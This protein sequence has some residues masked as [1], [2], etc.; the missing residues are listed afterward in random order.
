MRLNGP[1]THSRSFSPALSLSR[2]VRSSPHCHSVLTSLASSLRGQMQHDRGQ[3]HRG[4]GVGKVCSMPAC[5]HGVFK[6]CSPHNSNRK[7]KLI[8][9]YEFVIKVKW[10]GESEWETLIHTYQPSYI[11]KGRTP[12]DNVVNGTITIP[13]LS[14]E[15]DI[16]EVDVIAA[17]TS[18]TTPERDALYRSL[19]KQATTTV[20]K[21]LTEWLKV[22]R[23]ACWAMPS[24]QQQHTHSLLQLL[25]EQYALDIILPTNH[26]VAQ[27]D[28]APVLIHSSSSSG[29]IASQG[30]TPTP[31]S[32]GTSTATIELR[33]E[34]KCT[35][36]D[37]FNAL[38]QDNVWALALASWMLAYS[39]RRLS[40]RTR[41]ATQRSTR[42]WAARSPSSAGM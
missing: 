14:E 9:F 11:Y 10:T 40:A 30:A 22:G 37:L 12:L 35:P 31:Q 6:A 3:Q 20:R 24:L 2:Q 25:K 42:K 8:F 33:E 19:R 16:G 38:L 18:E 29:S 23:D 28:R 34:F 17:M 32:H 36:A 21:Q 39:H 27:S 4:R 26:K 5:T 41:A 15:N 7:G 13:N 1:R